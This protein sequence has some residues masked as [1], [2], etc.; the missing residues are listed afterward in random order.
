MAMEM[1]GSGKLD[2]FEEDRVA[3]VAERVAGEGVLQADGG[4]DG[5]GV[6]LLDLLAVVGVHAQEA[7]DA[8]S[9]A[10]GGVVDRGPRG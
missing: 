8:L 4:D 2:R 9:L 5:A 10:A 3:Q 6:D 1:T 7:A